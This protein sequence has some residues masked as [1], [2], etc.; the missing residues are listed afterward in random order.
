M[1]FSVLFPFSHSPM[2]RLAR[3]PKKIDERVNIGSYCVCVQY[4]LHKHGSL[5]PLIYCHVWRSS[6]N[7]LL[8]IHIVRLVR[9]R[10]M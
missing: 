2:M 4:I 6:N 8:Q 3:T 9:A 7:L 10:A 1:V 5:S